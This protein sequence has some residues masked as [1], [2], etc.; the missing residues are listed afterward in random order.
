MEI[1]GEW[2]IKEGETE[3]LNVRER[4][5]KV[6][7]PREKQWRERRKSETCELRG[8]IERKSK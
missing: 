2:G 8:E 3:R 1:D 7:L 5:I 6:V 4:Q